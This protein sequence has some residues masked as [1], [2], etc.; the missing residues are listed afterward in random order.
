[1]KKFDNQTQ[2]YL[3]KLRAALPGLAKKHGTP[4]FIISRTLLLAQ[5][6]R[7]RKLLPR[8]EPFYAVKANPNPEVIKLL[9]RHGCGF[10]VASEPEMEL[11]L[12]AG[13]EPERLIFAN[14]IKR[15]GAIQFARHRRVNLMT[16]DSEYELTKIARYAPG[17]RV[18]V[19]IKVPNVGSVVELSLKF[20]AEPSD[21]VP[22][23]LKARK[24]GLE[25][26]GIAFHVGSQC[27]YGNNYLE[28]L[29]LAK[30]ILAEAAQKGLKLTM[31]DIGGGFPIRHFDS[32]EDWFAEMAPALNLELA[33]LFAPEI[34]IIAEP[35]R[36]LIG[37]AAILV[38]SVIGKSIRN[39]KH[40]YYLDDGVYGA[41]S[42]TIFDHCKYQFEAFKRGPTQLTT[43]AG[44]TCDSLD[45]ISPAEEL[46]ELELGDLVFARNIG[47]Y[48]ITH[49]TSFNGIPP[50]KTVVVP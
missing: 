11:V 22:F 23:L 24:L 40:W 2:T 9:A 6:S 4:L 8:V 10:D 21:A 45:I 5:L 1:M 14:T 38:M 35:G 18:L 28:A 50:A 15:T 49:A 19:R 12:G 43:L 44:P 33:R 39:N 29:E 3:K 48:S 27:T 37:P 42:G 20:G 34:R 16:F 17:A 46:P 7:F 32:D 26:V 25:P 30:I 13:V 31:I 41:L 36:T 47:A